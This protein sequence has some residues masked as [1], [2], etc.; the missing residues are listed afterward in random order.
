MVM[1]SVIEQMVLEEDF[2]FIYFYS[3][4]YR[5]ETRKEMVSRI[6]LARLNETNHLDNLQF[7]EEIKNDEQ[8]V[9]RFNA[10]LMS[11]IEIT[12]ITDSNLTYE[13]ALKRLDGFRIVLRD[14]NTSLR[15]T[16]HRKCLYRQ[17]KVVEGRISRVARYL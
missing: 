5:S 9:L 7:L 11:L 10:C 6:V 13:D 3:F 4:Q 12:Y 1:V 2:L 15:L 14:R 16:K 8:Q 17:A